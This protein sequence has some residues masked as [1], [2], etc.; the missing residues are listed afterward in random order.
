MHTCLFCGRSSDDRAYEYVYNK[1]LPIVAETWDEFVKIREGLGF[2]SS[3]MTPETV[4]SA[5]LVNVFICPECFD[6]NNQEEDFN[7]FMR[8]MMSSDELLG[9]N[10]K[11]FQWREITH[12]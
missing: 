7:E 5:L 9:E 10:Y 4:V 3:E 6:R 8:R 2:K 1:M 11:I 12:E